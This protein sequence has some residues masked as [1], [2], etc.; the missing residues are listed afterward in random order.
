MS[1][2]DK[3]SRET[4]RT[5]VRRELLDPQERWWSD[6]ELNQY[7]EDW[8]ITLQDECEF[9]WGSSTLVTSSATHSLSDFNPSILRLDRI[10]WNNARLAPR[11]KAALSET[12][13]EWRATSASTPY[14]VW[15]P[16]SERFIVWPTPSTSGTLLLE[17]PIEVTFA[18]NDAGVMQ[19][20][21]WTR[22]SAINYCCYRAHLRFG[23][24]QDTNRALRRKAKFLKQLDSYKSHLK[25]YFPDRY[26]TLKPAS[27]YEARI[28]N[29]SPNGAVTMPVIVSYFYTEEV[30]TGAVNGTNAAFT[31]GYA[32]SPSTSLQ[33]FVNGILQEPT[34]AYSLSGT[35]VT[36]T[37]DYI[38]QTGDSLRAYYRRVG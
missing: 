10:Y 38:P 2:A 18:N 16:D 23:P 6:D 20:P 30:P 34:T 27:K 12:D 25:Q 35:T 7:I 32:P 36:F 9:V 37:T 31:L 19:V 26:L 17:Y 33:L 14:V 8:Q 15:Q 29:P 11:F 3:W 24:N 5:A 28:L 13:L 21:A 1:F 4:I 22:Y